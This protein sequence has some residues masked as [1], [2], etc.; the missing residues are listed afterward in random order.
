MLQ[1]WP[2][3]VVVVA[4]PFPS[5]KTTE[6]LDYLFPSALT[7]GVDSAKNSNNPIF[8]ISV[9]FIFSSNWCDPFPMLDSNA[10]WTLLL[11]LGGN[12]HRSTAKNEPYIGSCQKGHV[13]ARCLSHLYI[14][15][16]SFIVSIGRWVWKANAHMVKFCKEK[17]TEILQL[18][19][20]IVHVQSVW[21]KMMFCK[22]KY[23]PR[24]WRCIYFLWNDIDCHSYVG[25]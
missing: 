15:I 18:V 20:F 13:T 14:S 2:V 1:W 4:T 8:S 24:P 10:G 7:L 23:K 9:D 21:R 16:V 5:S 25:T 17:K 3:V 11:C 22:N 12:R 19:V 6:L